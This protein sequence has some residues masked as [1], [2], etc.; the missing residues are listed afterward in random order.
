MSDTPQPTGKTTIAIDVLLTIASLTTLNITGVS[1]LS[2]P[3]TPRVKDLL[4]R[5]QMFEGVLIEVQDD[6][7]YV[8]L[9][10]IMKHDINIRDV[11]RKIQSEV[12]RAISEMVGMQVGRINIHVE[13][14]DYPLE[15]EA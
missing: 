2:H 11:G 10:I 13:D 15:F 7:V 14:I 5:G 9:Y 1:R 12:A 3:P 6:T 4:K 8:D